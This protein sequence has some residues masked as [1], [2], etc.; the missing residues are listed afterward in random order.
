MILVPAVT[1]GKRQ[2]PGHQQGTTFCGEEIEIDSEWILTT[3]LQ[4]CGGLYRTHHASP[5][6]LSKSYSEVCTF[7]RTLMYEEQRRRPGC[8]NVVH[9]A[10][11]LRTYRV[12][13]IRYQISYVN[14]Y[15]RC[16]DS[17]YC[18]DTVSYSADRSE[19]RDP[20]K[21]KHVFSFKV[22]RRAINK[23]VTID[24]LY[25]TAIAFV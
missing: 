17:L 19:T 8:R 11:V 20:I 24:Q 9:S 4:C 1:W 10:S 6:Q 13:R 12:I 15:V 18:K 23:M 7:L 21:D 3:F 2:R 5:S 22:R 25:S 16:T 14:T